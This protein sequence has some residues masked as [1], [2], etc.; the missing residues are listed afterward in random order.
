M[1]KRAV[2][3]LLL[4]AI[5]CC[6]SYVAF[7]PQPRTGGPAFVVCSYQGDYIVIAPRYAQCGMAGSKNPAEAG[8]TRVLKILP[9]SQKPAPAAGTRRVILSAGAFV[10][11]SRLPAL[12]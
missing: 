5:P 7:R 2:V 8:T 10:E 12:Q 6:L 9:S 1:L 3:R 4:V 11:S